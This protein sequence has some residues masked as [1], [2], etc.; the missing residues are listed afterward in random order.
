MMFSLAVGPILQLAV[1]DFHQHHQFYKLNSINNL[2]ETL[3]T[4]QAAPV[5][6]FFRQIA[7][8]H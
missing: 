5:I 3:Y 2:Q 1:D 4:Q 6:F 8:E 7:C